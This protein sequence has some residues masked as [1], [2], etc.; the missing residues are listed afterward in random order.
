MTGIRM[1]HEASHTLLSEPA[2]SNATLTGEPTPS[3][4][5]RFV[6]GYFPGEGIGPE[7]AGVAIDLLKAIESRFGIPF[8]LF[9]GGAIGSEAIAE[10]GEPLSPRAAALIE[11]VF[12][13]GGAVLA[14]P[15]CDRFVYDLRQRFDLY[16]K[17]NPIR[18]FPEL[19]G[20][21]PLRAECLQDADILV[22]RENVSGL[23]M[24]TAR[25]C[26]DDGERQLEC[27]F[28]HREGNVRRLLRAA[29][30]LARGRRGMLTV[31]G[32]SS[33]LPELSAMW[34]ALAAE[35]AAQ[36]GIEHAFLDVDY[37][38]YRMLAE[39]S[40]FDVIAAPNCFGDILSDLGGILLGSRGMT[41]GASY[42]AAGGAV[43]QTNHGAARDLA[44]TDR[45]NPV[46]QMGALAM[47][48]QE[49]FCLP[50]VAGCVRRSIS[51]VLADDV[52]PPDL[53]FPGCVVAGTREFGRRVA[54]AIA[55]EATTA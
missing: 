26:R 53:A 13:A 40:W 25:E 55:N 2:R 29:A 17:L 15:G 24:G 19:A 30:D 7:L 3:A 32:K 36:A 21:G 48:M 35:E 51:R 28:T 1:T 42:S 47:M 14:G 33:G 46:G 41:F 31:I 50:D 12:A 20:A 18:P 6:L 39:P 49:S 23:Y 9:E 43:Y 11:S 44:G 54:A 45:A 34:G 38:A 5:R 4:A 52:R 10:C 22:V 37:A 16:C 8:E 27:R